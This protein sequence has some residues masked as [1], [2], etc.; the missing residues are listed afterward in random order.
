VLAQAGAEYNPAVV[1]AFSYEL[2][3]TFNSF[4][5]QCGILKEE[6]ATRK[7]LRLQLTAL[8]GQCIASSMSL[9][10]VSMPSRM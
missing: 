5:Q 6:D 8:T 3:K 7:S 10:G 4:Y 1:A 2:T 9:L